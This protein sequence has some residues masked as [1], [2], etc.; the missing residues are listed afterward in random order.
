MHLQISVLD[1]I[2]VLWN[3]MISIPL[4]IVTHCFC[5]DVVGTLP[6]AH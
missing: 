1:V 2:Y 5:T 6:C 4:Q 3:S